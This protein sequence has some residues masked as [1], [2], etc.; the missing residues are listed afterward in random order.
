M[1]AIPENYGD[2]YIKVR[3]YFSEGKQPFIPIGET[4]EV[5]RTI[6]MCQESAR[7]N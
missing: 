7:G 5:M 1:E 4:L 2:F 3:E 6:E